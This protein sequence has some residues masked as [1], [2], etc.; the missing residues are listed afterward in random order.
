MDS[1]WQCLCGEIEYSDLEPKEC[2]ACGKIGAFTQ[3]PAELIDE[4][5]KDADA[6]LDESELALDSRLES[7]LKAKAVKSKLAKSKLGKPKLK[8]PGRRK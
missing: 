2:L 6:D 1:A 5:M 8:K 3:L 7:N 4:R